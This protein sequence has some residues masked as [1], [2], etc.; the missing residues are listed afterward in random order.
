MHH[1]ITLLWIFFTSLL[2]IL[3]TVFYFLNRKNPVNRAFALLLLII[4][5]F[6]VISIIVISFQ[7][8]EA[9]WSILIMP[10]LCYLGL[11]FSSFYQ[12]RAGRASAARPPGKD[13]CHSRRC[14]WSWRGSRLLFGDV[15]AVAAF[16]MVRSGEVARAS[17]FLSQ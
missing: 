6:S 17:R 14:E 12:S 3:A 2:A 8:V 9:Y 5:Y 15:I 4:A 10:M 11:V 13:A 16:G 7:A 1:G